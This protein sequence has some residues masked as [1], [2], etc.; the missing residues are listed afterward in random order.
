VVAS[1]TSL[2]ASIVSGGVLCIVGAVAILAAMPS[3]V[4]YDAKDA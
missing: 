1:L 2:R 4:R 3:L